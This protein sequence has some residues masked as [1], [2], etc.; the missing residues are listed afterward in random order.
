MAEEN[1]TEQELQNTLKKAVQQSL[2]QSMLAKGLHETCKAI[3]AQTVKLVVLADDCDNKDIVA[4]V[5]ALC[6]EYKVSILAIA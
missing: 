3:E 2:H 1:A 4:L 5:K 6:E